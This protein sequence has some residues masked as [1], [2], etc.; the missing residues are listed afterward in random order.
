MSDTLPIALSPGIQT[1]TDAREQTQPR[2]ARTASNGS[3]GAELAITRIAQ[4]RDNVPDFVQVI[5]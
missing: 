2:P 5:I 1:S 4:T 3:A